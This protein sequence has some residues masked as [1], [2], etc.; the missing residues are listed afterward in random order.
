MNT[1]ETFKFYKKNHLYTDSDT[2]QYSKGT[3]LKIYKIKLKGKNSIIR[4]LNPIAIK[5]ALFTNYFIIGV[6]FPLIIFLVMGLLTY[7]LSLLDFSDNI[8]YATLGIVGLLLFIKLMLSLR[9]IL[10]KVKIIKDYKENTLPF[11]INFENRE[12][13][14]GEMAYNFDDISNVK[15]IETGNN[16]LCDTSQS[17]TLQTID[18]SNSCIY[19]ITKDNKAILFMIVKTFML[20][21]EDF[22][23]MMSY[24]QEH[25]ITTENELENSVEIE[26]KDT[27]IENEIENKENI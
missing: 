1:K 16:N 12:I 10:A 11:S 5:K 19:F 14:S 18:P 17:A 8:N 20:N 24:I 22:Q 2:E 6:M 27:T 3:L 13:I 4:T 15:V 7:I 21:N 26:E 25:V 9:K 23:G